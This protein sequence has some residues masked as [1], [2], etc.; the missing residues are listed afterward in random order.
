MKKRKTS[1]LAA[2]CAAGLVFANTGCEWDSGGS[3]SGFNTSRGAGAE[4]NFSGYYQG[5]LSGGRAVDRTSRGNITTFVITQSGN[6]I[7]VV[8]NTGT[9][10]SGS[11]GSPGVVA[12]P[13]NGVYPA[14]A[15]LVQGQINFSDDRSE[16]VGIIH[17]VAV[18][19]IQGSESSSSTGS[20]ETNV[21]RYEEG[22][23]TVEVTTL[24]I[25]SPG[26]P[27]YQVTTTTVR[28][29][30][31]T[32]REISRT[33]ETT[34]RTYSNF[35]ITEANSQYRLQ[36]TWIDKGGGSSSVKAR[37]SGAIGTISASTEETT[38]T[39]TDTPEG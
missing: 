20:S 9:R 2:A 5:E 21:E 17:V 37:S 4:I 29:D 31:A 1:F 3:D 32:G 8:D 14:G 27:F 12:Q 28:R 24:T 23:T 39:T 11:V 16:F 30:T 15:N 13:S 25:G 6:R 26:D 36:G 33:T 18:T 10:Y 19:D 38:T 7:D 22:D 34:G 35:Q